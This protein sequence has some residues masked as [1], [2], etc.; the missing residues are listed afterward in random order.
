MGEEVE[1]AD[2]DALPHHS[3]ATHLGECP[4]THRGHKTKRRDN[5]CL[6]IRRRKSDLL[7]IGLEARNSTS[8]WNLLQ[9]VG[10]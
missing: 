8:G 9:D 3:A 4:T 6:Q 2:G 10:Q 7:E 5:H 1:G